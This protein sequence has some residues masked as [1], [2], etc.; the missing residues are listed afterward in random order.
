ML[1]K[2]FLTSLLASGLL[3][4]KFVIGESPTR[5]NVV[6]IVTDDQDAQWNSLDFMPQVQ[7]HLVKK[8]T[9]YKK[10]YCT[11]S[12]C[13]PSRVS[14][15][16]GKA[17][18][19]TNVTNVQDPYGGYPQFIREGH[20]ENWVPLWIQQAGYQTFYTGK[21]MN[22]QNITNYD[23]PFISGFNGSDFLLDPNTYSY[24]NPIFQRNHDKPIPHRNEYSTDL[25]KQKALGFLDDAAK[26]PSTPFYLTI[27]PIAPHSDIGF[28]A[29]G[30]D[31]PFAVDVSAPISAKRH[32]HLFADE[33][34]PRTPNFN[35]EVPSGVDWIAE[36]PRLNAENITAA[37]E[38]HR[39]RM[40]SLMAVD[41]MVG[42]VIARLERH[43]VLDN[44]Y[45]FYSTDN[46][47]HNGQHRLGPGKNCGFEEDI[48]VP[49]VVRGPKVPKGKEVELAT[50]HTDLGA[51][52]FKV[53]GIPHREDFDGA[54]IPLTE[55]DIQKL[56]DSGKAREHVQVEY[57]GYTRPAESQDTDTPKYNNT[58]KAIRVVG[59]EYGFYYSVWCSSVNELY[60][61]K[62][63]PG[64]M[65][66]LFGNPGNSNTSL[67]NS[68]YAKY[69]TYPTEP[70]LVTLGNTS[71]PR[72]TLISRLDGLLLV[73]KTCKGKT[74]V[75]PWDTVLPGEGITTLAAAMHKQYN[76]YFADMPKVSFDTCLEGYLEDNEH[77]LWE[78]GMA[79]PG[80]VV[81]KFPRAFGRS[82][83]DLP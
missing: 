83:M 47:Y 77:P 16:T 36:L 59:Q 28:Q 75:S 29:T 41:E 9:N 20:N 13:C 44:T 26:D 71:Y 61:M 58:Y 49:L 15:F 32:E 12:W 69:P 14:I 51:T 70:P 30:G 3:H 33:I 24:M 6:F 2:A 79:R 19:N 27:A 64:Q 7:E 11:V 1:H 8:G 34:I 56:S 40:R 78:D 35:P 67:P 23:E 48:N 81:P 80:Q 66:N 37:D 73:L 72:D 39:Q 38:W 74:C 18:H 10:H 22:A 82:T 55:S 46:G 60:D 5:P 52:W 65:N 42:E 54:P 68:T 43:G 53:M 31:P 76:T 17:A 4:S 57:W 50:S 45:I 62:A 25:V 63:D 21:L